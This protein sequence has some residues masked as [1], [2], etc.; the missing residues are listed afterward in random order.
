MLLGS[1]V[2]YPEA[3]KTPPVPRT[4]EMAVHGFHIENGQ[5]DQL[6]DL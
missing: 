4:F 6:S 2:F 1:T 3:A 5:F